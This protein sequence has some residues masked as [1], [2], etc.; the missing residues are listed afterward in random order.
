MIKEVPLLNDAT[1]H[2]LSLDVGKPN[3]ASLWGSQVAH[4]YALLG[5]CEFVSVSLL[6]TIAVK[7]TCKDNNIMPTDNLQATKQLC[8]IL[9]L[10]HVPTNPGQET[11]LTLH[12]VGL[13]P[14]YK[15]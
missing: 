10:S 15:V 11:G 12:G 13:N 4:M 1:A 14:G 3:G 7:V 8:T 9:P 6:W 2:K 5:V